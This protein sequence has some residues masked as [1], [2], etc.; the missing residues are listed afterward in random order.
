MNAS[1]QQQIIFNYLKE[2]GKA[3]VR[4]LFIKCNINSPTK[5]LSELNKK[6]PLHKLWKE[7]GNTRYVEYSLSDGL[8]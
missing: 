3:T 7:R 5:R 2:N 8:V 4:D 1:K 6:Q